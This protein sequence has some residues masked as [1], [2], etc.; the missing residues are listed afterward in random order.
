M[1]MMP[2]KRP[3]PAVK[4]EAEMAELCA[5]SRKVRDQMLLAKLREENERLRQAKEDAAKG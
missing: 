5:R 1:K 3:R 2:D 4:S